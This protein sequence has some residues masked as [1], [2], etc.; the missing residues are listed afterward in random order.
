MKKILIAVV[1]LVGGVQAQAGIADKVVRSRAGG[2]DVITYRTSI[3]DVVTI[4]G[5]L[6]AGDA[7]A[8]SNQ[9]AL[10]T[11]TGMMLDR[12]TLK[13]DKFSI[14]RR[15]EDVGASVDFSVDSQT[16]DI[17]ARCLS[18]DLPM[19]IALI[20]EQLRQPAFP[21]EE[22]ERVRQQFIGAVRSSIEDSSFRVRDAFNRALFP[23]EHPNHP[24]SIEQMLQSAGV[25]TLAQAKAF[26]ETHYGPANLVLVFVGDISDATVRKAMTAG[27]G[28]WA[29]GVAPLGGPGLAPPLPPARTET[30]VLDAKPSVSVLLGQRTGLRYRDP[31]SLALRLGTAVLGS[32]FTGRLMSS[33][34]ERE[35]LTYDIGASVSDDTFN[36]GAFAI[37]ASFAPQLLEKGLNSARR[38]LRAWWADGIKAD[39]LAARKQNLI[40][41][42]QVG[43]ST[44]NG[45]ASAMLSTAQRGL[46]L[47]WLDRYPDAARA[48]TLE[49]VNAAIRK[50][51]DPDRMTLVEVGTLPAAAKP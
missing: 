16:V 40:G 15:L 7:F 49:Q 2:V 33:V 30:V 39:E 4:T 24:Q 47:A 1:L 10:A 27:F 28:G 14:A 37:R 42:Y 6:P 22:F 11:L 9:A 41:R 50:Y 48:L 5:S 18:K 29:G 25:A 32:G 21:P 12:G 20:A 38:E 36:D 19:V 44:S 13:Q 51:L 23:A 31:D 46:D 8:P 35:G 26:H 34:R 45:L 3:K 43:L 17:R